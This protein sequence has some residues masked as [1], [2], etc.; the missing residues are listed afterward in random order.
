MTELRK[1]MYKKSIK[2]LSTWAVILLTALC[3][4]ACSWKNSVSVH[5]KK[6]DF[7]SMSIDELEQYIELGAY[8]DLQISSEGRSRG[9]AVWD[10]VAENASIKEYPEEHVYYYIEQRQEQYKYYA[11]EA[12]ISYKE[13]L[14][15]LGINEGNIIKEAKE[16]TERDVLYALIVK[17]EKI[18]LGEAEKSTHFDRYAKKYVSEYGYDEAYVK[19]N[20]TELIY[21]SMLY[22]KTTE[23]LIISNTIN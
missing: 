16:L 2:L 11:E 9:E 1:G 5:P 3:F 4:C 20:M 21:D 15:E 6:L 14:E 13:M 10:A 18:E 12:G 19:E 23:F 17:I 8:R 22:D 7:H